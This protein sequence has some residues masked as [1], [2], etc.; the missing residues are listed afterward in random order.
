MMPF[1]SIKLEISSLPAP[2]TVLPKITF[3]PNQ[4]KIVNDNEMLT[5]WNDSNAWNCRTKTADWSFGPFWQLA[6]DTNHLER[7]FIR[8]EGRHHRWSTVV[9]HLLFPQCFQLPRLWK[10]GYKHHIRKY[11]FLFLQF[12]F[13][14]KINHS[15]ISI[16]NKIN[17]VT[18]RLTK[19][20]WLCRAPSWW[21]H[22]GLQRS[23]R[24]TPITSPAQPKLFET[25]WTLEQL[26][27]K[28]TPMLLLCGLLNPNWP[29]CAHISH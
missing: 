13:H 6:N 26:M 28:S 8:L 15:M 23:W 24:L 16:I 25:I 21:I 4:L 12:N 10:H 22:L 17:F 19:G 20:R 27:P 2:M 11:Y 7:V 29:R 3:E 14:F 1:R 9:R 18:F 5:I